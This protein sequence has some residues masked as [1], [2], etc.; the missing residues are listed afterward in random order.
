M[1]FAALDRW[2]RPLRAHSDSSAR[3]AKYPA[4]IFF[5]IAGTLV[6]PKHRGVVARK[7][8]LLEPLPADLSVPWC[9]RQTFQWDSSRVGSGRR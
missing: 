3:A 6:L 2:R 4:E 5:S 8:V 7:Q 9:F 1:L